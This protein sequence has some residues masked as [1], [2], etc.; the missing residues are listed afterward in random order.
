[1]S[2]A[3]WAKLIH[4]NYEVDLLEYARW[5]G[6]ILRSRRRAWASASTDG[7]AGKGFEG[8][9]LM[10]MRPS[11]TSEKCPAQTSRLPIMLAMAGPTAGDGIEKA[12]RQPTPA[13]VSG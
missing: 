7:N 8:R 6:A 13:G 1:M 10:K 4:E 9:D 5:E 3:A 12:H 11:S 2:K